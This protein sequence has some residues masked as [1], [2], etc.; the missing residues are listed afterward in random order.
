M[1]LLRTDFCEVQGSTMTSQATPRPG[2]TLFFLLSRK[3]KLGFQTHVKPHEFAGS[4]SCMK[5]TY[6]RPLPRGARRPHRPCS[7][8]SHTSW[9]PNP[10]AIMA[11]S[12]CRTHHPSRQHQSTSPSSSQWL[13]MA[14]TGHC[15]SFTVLGDRM[16]SSLPPVLLPSSSF[17][18]PSVLG[19]EPTVLCQP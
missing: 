13:G 3:L 10:S 12:V 5:L 9:S 18:P 17:L 4:T 8:V 19:M 6:Q 15:I 1:W 11:S 16:Y 2:K 14:D 7:T